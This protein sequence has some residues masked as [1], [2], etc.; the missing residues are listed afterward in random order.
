MAEELV[1]PTVIHNL[2]LE[3]VRKRLITKKGWTSAH[4]DRMIEEYRE[5]LALFYFHPEDELVPPSQ[6]LDDVWH[7]HILDTQRYSE[8]C[9]RVF[10]R[11]IHH[12][13]GLEHGTHRHTEGLERTRRHWWQRFGRH[14]R[15]KLSFRRNDSGGLEMVM[16]GSSCTSYMPPASDHGSFFG[17][18]FSGGESGGAGGG[19]EFGGHATD[20]NSGSDSGDAGGGGDSGGGDGGGGDGGGCGGGGGGCGGG[21]D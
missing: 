7:E 4:A 14:R 5:Y 15:D 3:A 21:G 10:G 1:V 11:F 19:A 8:D 6:D 18:W 17:G 9:Q 12:V 13:P 20:G 2:D 16:L